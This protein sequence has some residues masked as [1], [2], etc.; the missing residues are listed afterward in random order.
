MINFYV[1]KNSTLPVLRIELLLD[2]RNLYNISNDIITGSTIYFS[3]V[4]KS[5]NILKVGKSLCTITNESGKLFITYKFSGKS[6][7][8]VG[9]FIGEFFITDSK[10]LEVIPITEKINI[11]VLD[12][13]FNTNTVE[14]CIQ[15]NIP[16]ILLSRTPTATPTLT[17]TPFPSKTPIPTRT[18]T[19]TNTPTRTVTPTITKTPTVTPTIT[20]TPTQT[21]TTTPTNTKTPTQTST[22]TPTNTVTPTNT[23]TP[24]PSVT[25]GLSPTPTKSITPTITATITSTPTNTLTPT[26]TKT[27]TPSPE[28]SYFNIKSSIDNSLSSVS[29]TV[30]YSIYDGFYLN[31]D[32]PYPTGQTWTQ[33]GATSLIPLCN[34]EV[35][36]GI[37]T[38]PIFKTL[39]LQI[40]NEDGS[41]IYKTD[42]DFLANPCSGPGGSSGYTYTILIGG[43]LTVDINLKITDPISTVPAPINV[44]PTPTTTQTPTNTL[45]PTITPTN[46]VTTTLTTTPTNTKTP[47]Q[48][49]TQTAT[50]TPTNTVTPSPSPLPELVVDFGS[51][52]GSGSTKVIYIFTAS[53]ISDQNIIISFDNV[54]YNK[55]TEEQVIISTGVTIFA[56]SITGKTEVTLR[57]LDYSNLEKG[58]T[59]FINV[60]STRVNTS[61]NKYTKVTFE[62]Y[63]PITGFAFFEKCCDRSDSGPDFI[64]VQVT[65]FDW[66]DSGGGVVY[67]NTCYKPLRFP[68]VGATFIG[69]RYGADFFGECT[70]QRFCSCYIPPSATPTRTPTQTPTR[71]LTPTN[72]QTPTITSTITPS[73]SP[74][75]TLN[76]SATAEEFFLTCESTSTNYYLECESITTI[77]ELQCSVST[78]PYFIECVGSS[79]DFVIDC[80]VATTPYFIECESSIEFVTPTV[81][82]TKTSTPT[83][84]STQTSTPTITNTQTPTQTTTITRTP[85]RTPTKTPTR[86]VT[87]TPEATKTPVAVSSSPTPSP[88]R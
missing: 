56:G 53:S 18:S 41:E 73:P 62:D 67:E 1:R 52:Y 30:W 31:D 5:T 34:D 64:E 20:K 3:M 38:V 39:F 61:F 78:R 23:Q 83:L 63:T 11:I 44:T 50:L 65:S 75:Y 33:L 85:T 45:T 15:E 17:Q 42:S 71:T 57:E 60:E 74:V 86:T 24:T 7:S 51:E 72:T 43:P 32:E 22:K 2:G 70:E 84:T 36:F 4:D 28:P 21:P 14:C 69:L 27:P 9:E 49:V 40:R 10:G 35:S 16:T 12:S 6:L 55:I 58:S 88:S 81:T 68:V 80:S 87:R 26:N 47:T 59:S 48:T 8:S 77:L 54:L 82:P 13:I 29:G 79:S 37:L 66:V 25:S 19:P 46:T 76:C